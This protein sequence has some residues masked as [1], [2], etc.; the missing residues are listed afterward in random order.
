MGK[1]S[2]N[3]NKKGADGDQESKELQLKLEEK[4][5][6]SKENYEKYLRIAAELDNFKKHSS[7]E[8][9]ELVRY[10]NEN[11]IKEILPILDN[12]DRAL[13]HAEKA[14]DIDAF[15]EGLK[16]IRSQFLQRLEKFGVKQVEAVGSEFDPNIHEAVLSV[17]SPDHEDNRVMD[18]FEKGYL[19]NDRLLKPARVSVTKRKPES[20]EL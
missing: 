19:L 1:N 7:K 2:D 15:I 13:D 8:R 11:L 14:R 6:E 9:S 10:G 5:K 18:E 20:E 17:D 4:E 16:L 12:M 3:Q